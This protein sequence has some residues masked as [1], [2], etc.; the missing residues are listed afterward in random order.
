MGS[1][2]NETSKNHILYKPYSSSK[3]QK[4]EFNCLPYNHSS[5]SVDED[6]IPGEFTVSITPGKLEESGA[7]M[8]L[9]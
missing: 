9:M 3:I 2:I 1:V 5:F 6:I 4:I 7:T 8:G